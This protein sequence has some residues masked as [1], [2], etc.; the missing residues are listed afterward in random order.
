[1]TAKID[2]LQAGNVP[3]VS[4]DSG[5]AALMQ[6][7]HGPQAHEAQREY[8]DAL[9][10][11]TNPAR[12]TSGG[13]DVGTLKQPTND[14][15]RKRSKKPVQTVQ[16]QMLTVPWPPQEAPSLKTLDSAPQVGDSAFV[17]RECWPSYPCNEF[18]GEGW[19]A[20]VQ[21]K[22]RYTATVSFGY[23]QTSR[24]VAYA[25]ERLDWMILKGFA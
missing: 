19:A 5:Y 14:A 15:G 22:T 16:E 18:A 2:V 4:A 13:T 12:A 20:T 1:M 24:G 6:G 25:D 23:A 9:R 10:A 7:I 11:A 8:E 21:S 17:P 3:V